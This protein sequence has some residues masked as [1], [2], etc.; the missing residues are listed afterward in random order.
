MFG[1][2]KGIPM[3]YDIE[4]DPEFQEELARLEKEDGN[5]PSTAAPISL[6]RYPATSPL[7]DATGNPWVAFG[8]EPLTGGGIW[9]PDDGKKFL[10]MRG[11]YWST[12]WL[13]M[14]AH[15]V[16]LWFPVDGSNLRTDAFGFAAT[17]QC[18]GGVTASGWNGTQWV[19][20]QGPTE[21][22]RGPVISP[23][24]PVSQA[25]LDRLLAR[26]PARFKNSEGGLRRGACI[27]VEQAREVFRV[28]PPPSLLEEVMNEDY[29]Y[30]K[31]CHGS[32]FLE[33]YCG[34]SP[35]EFAVLHPPD[36]Y[37]PDF[38]DHL[39]A[40]VAAMPPHA[41]RLWAAVLAGDETARRDFA[42]MVEIQGDAGRASLLRMGLDRHRTLDAAWL[43]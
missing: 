28:E 21:F 1:S 37:S 2:R 33:W 12:G 36:D 23:H 42:D 35:A 43:V 18:L 38:R 32:V 6:P 31:V 8:F 15:D 34:I 41:R 16:T 13:L 20:D 9:N 25:D 10:G 24:P 3:K 39:D 4:N 29:Q 40:L 30:D 27:D 19:T 17:L 22:L 14:P 7:L 26:V 11:C 5:A